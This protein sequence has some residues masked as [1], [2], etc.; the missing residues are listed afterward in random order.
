MTERIRLDDMTDDELDQLYSELDRYRNAWQSARRRA[1]RIPATRELLAE[2]RNSTS[3]N[4]RLLAA[5]WANRLERALT[6]D[7]WWP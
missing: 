1:R 6:Q 2:L 3:P 5:G 7:P 4:G